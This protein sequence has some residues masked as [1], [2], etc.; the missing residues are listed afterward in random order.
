MQPAESRAQGLGFPTFAVVALLALCASSVLA[1]PAAFDVDLQDN[2]A[3]PVPQSESERRAEIRRTLDQ[4]PRKGGSNRDGR[5]R[6]SDEER[7][8]LRKDIGDAARDVY[9]RRKGKNSA[10]KRTIDK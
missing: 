7:R 5:Q 9:E 6:L 10:S 8:D 4:H 2:A 1:Q 3:P